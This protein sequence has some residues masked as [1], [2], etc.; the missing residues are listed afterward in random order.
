MIKPEDM[1]TIIGSIFQADLPQLNQISDAC[2]NQRAL[3]SMAHKNKFNLD[4]R[5]VFRTRAGQLLNGSIVKINRKTIGVMTDTDGEWRV[6][7]NKL[8]WEEIIDIEE[9]PSGH[10]FK[11][12]L[13]YG[14]IYFDTMKPHK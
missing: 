8:S 5:V 9:D 6:Y 11:V 13:P 10:L 3:I 2:R 7:P 14:R 1:I 4:D 12:M